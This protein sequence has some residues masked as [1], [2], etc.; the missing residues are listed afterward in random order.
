MAINLEANSLLRIFFFWMTSTSLL[1]IPFIYCM[2][3][4]VRGTE[5]KV[6][7][8]VTTDCESK[9][10]MMILKDYLYWW[11]IVEEGEEIDIPVAYR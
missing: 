4:F 6:G 2:T 9:I 1:A 11:N 5:S 3:C 10:I 7:T 8:P